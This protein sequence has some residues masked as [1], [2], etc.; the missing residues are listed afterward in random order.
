LCSNTEQNFDPIFEQAERSCRHITHQTQDCWETATQTKHPN[1]ISQ[2]ILSSQCGY[3]PL[4]D[5]IITK[6]ETRFSEATRLSVKILC[7]IPALLENEAA[8]VSL[9]DTIAYLY[10]DVLPC[11]QRK[12]PPTNLG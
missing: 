12:D 4:L 2:Q 7:L 6:M 11:V 3:S 10:E 1:G 5:H 9:D 8:C